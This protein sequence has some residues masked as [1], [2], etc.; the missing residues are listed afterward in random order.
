MFKLG[1]D[2]TDIQTNTLCH[3]VSFQIFSRLFC[4]NLCHGTVFVG[5][6]AT[7]YILITKKQHTS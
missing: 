4:H 6:K 2:N 7:L 5:Q 1:K 3:L